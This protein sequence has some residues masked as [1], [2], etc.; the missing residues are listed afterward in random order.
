MVATG[1]AQT[2]AIRDALAFREYRRAQFPAAA[3]A[4]N[5][6]EIVEGVAEYTGVVAGEPDVYAAR[7][8]AVSRLTHPDLDA[9]FVRSFAY[10]SGP[11]YGLLLDERLPGWR[12][13]LSAESDLGQL[14][15]ST[16]K[17]KGL[18]SAQTRAPY[19]GATEIKIF[20]ADR[21]TQAAAEQARYRA[22]LVEGP[23]LVTP[24]PGRFSFVP[25]SLI[26]LGEAGTVYPTFHAE[27]SWGTLD[28]KAG[29]LVPVDFSS[30]TLPAPKDP[31]GPHIEGPGWTIDLVPGWS[32]VP[33]AKAG[34][35]VLQGP[36]KGSN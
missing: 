5:G 14:L 17:Q 33:A 6:Q 4:E 24:K 30:T 29:V 13:K 19:Y 8:H 36:A 22:L 21:A 3:E 16:L 34:N 15:G 7:W 18:V 1:P 25:T 2:S 32:I 23:V 28:V 31:H 27:A 26:S 10:V 11:G 9:S 35:Y 12:S 20:E